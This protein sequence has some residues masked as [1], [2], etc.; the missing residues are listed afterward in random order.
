MSKA[1]PTNRHITYREEYRRCGRCSQ[2]LA[3]GTWT[4]AIFVRLLAQS[5]QQETRKQVYGPCARKEGGAM[6]TIKSEGHGWKL[7]SHDDGKRV[8]ELECPYGTIEII[9]VIG[10]TELALFEAEYEYN[11]L[12]AMGPIES[13]A[14]S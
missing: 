9:A 5:L 14:P 3:G 6:N 4:R 7:T 11:R 10:D 2:C 12:K 8:L 1:L 13:E